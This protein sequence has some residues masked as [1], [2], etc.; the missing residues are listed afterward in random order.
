MELEPVID[1]EA[2]LLH[3]RFMYAS[4]LVVASLTEQ[5]RDKHLEEADKILDGYNI[6]RITEGQL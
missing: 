4:A 6:L 5:D 3:D 1:N 2:Q